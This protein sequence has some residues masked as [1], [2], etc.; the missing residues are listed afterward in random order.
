MVGV[1]GKFPDPIQ[2]DLLLESLFPDGQ[3]DGVWCATRIMDLY[4]GSTPKNSLPSLTSEEISIIDNVLG[5]FS[6]I[7]SHSFRRAFWPATAFLSV[8]A[9]GGVLPPT[10]NLAGPFRCPVYGPYFHLP[11]GVWEGLCMVRIWDNHGRVSYRLDV[12]SDT[13][14][15]EADILLPVSGLHEFRFQF[16]NDNPGSA[17]QVRFIQ[18]RGA[19]EG[20]MQFD[21]V[22]V[23]RVG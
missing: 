6:Q 2:I 22:E 16:R 9:D 1:I 13:P 12:F 14:H 18:T 19:I 11:R 15:F 20:M 4:F 21:G 7:G 3:V 10:I 8:D 23:S 5:E 17:L